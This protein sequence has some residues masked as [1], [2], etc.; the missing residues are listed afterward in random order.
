MR[1]QLEQ[2]DRCITDLLAGKEGLGAQMT[3]DA[4][5]SETRFE[6]QAQVRA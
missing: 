6:G 1:E 2:R 5:A 4:A 3:H